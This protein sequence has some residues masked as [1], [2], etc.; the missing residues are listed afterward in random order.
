[1]SVYTIAPQETKYVNEV[2]HIFYLLRQREIFVD[3]KLLMEAFHFAAEVHRGQK[4]FSGEPFI[5]HPVAVMKILAEHSLPDSETLASALLHDTL[6]DTKVKSEPVLLIAHFGETIFSLVKGVTKLKPA[7]FRGEAELLAQTLRRFVFDTISD[8]RVLQMK[9]A[10]RLH[11]LLTAEYLPSEDQRRRMAQDAMDFYAPLAHRFGFHRLR[12]MV[13]DAALNILEPVWSAAIFRK[14]ERLK[15]RKAERIERLR[16][17]MEEAIQS[18]FP[19]IAFQVKG[20]FKHISA[21]YHK[22]KQQGLSFEEIR[23]IYGLRILVD[24]EENCYKILWL[25]H[26]TWEY[27]QGYFRDY[28][29][30]PK[31]NGYRSLHTLVV[32]EGGEPFEVQI[33]TFEMDRYAEYGYAAHWVYKNPALFARIRRDFSLLR[34][35]LSSEAYTE[36]PQYL[37]EALKLEAF[38]N[39][40]FVYT[41]KGERIYLPQGATALDFAFKVHTE[42]GQHFSQAIVNNREVSPDTVLHMGDVVQI[43]TSPD[44]E[45]HPTWLNLVVTPT[46]KKSIQD[47]LKKKEKETTA[48]EGK[49]ILEEEMVKKGWHNLNLLRAE[50]LQM[51]SRENR[52]KDAFHLYRAILQGKITPEEVCE[53]LYLLHQKELKRLV[54]EER[55]PEVSTRLHLSLPLYRTKLKILLQPEDEEIP[56]SAPVAF[57]RKCFPLPGDSVVAILAETG[58]RIHLHRSECIVILRPD[59]QTRQAIWKKPTAQLFPAEIRM[60]APNRRGLLKE[61]ISVITDAGINILSNQIK[62]F[63]TDVGSISMVL[64][65]HSAAQVEDLI[66]MLKKNVPDLLDVS[67]TLS[68]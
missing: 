33:R 40:T 21:I 4:R 8:I 31:P 55:L 7:F 1:M 10:D 20:R 67:R 63:R 11:N 43:V 56:L 28:I 29:G 41:P 14:L 19:G 42:I 5:S 18:H 36:N 39:E 9:M 38:S 37:L 47:Y 27:V 45:P 51:F 68:P 50:L 34:D 2:K 48:L 26:T 24:G 54:K 52:F 3:E 25:V 66:K 58:K 46:A 12:A 17:K 61:V 35:V 49:K 32:P 30:S 60:I 16:R 64:E 53:G 15:E 6:E 23:D 22:M 65:V 62:L 57:C 44:A 13:E 59:V